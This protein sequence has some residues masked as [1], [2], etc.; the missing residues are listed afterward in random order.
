MPQNF[1]IYYH[2]IEYTKFDINVSFCYMCTMYIRYF[3]LLFVTMIDL[4]LFAI[5]HRI[6]F[7]KNNLLI[8]DFFILKK[9]HSVT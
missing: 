8:I 9:I 1:S 3:V 4:F 5:Y 6:T 7:P 2:W